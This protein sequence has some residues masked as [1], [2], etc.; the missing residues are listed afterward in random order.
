MSDGRSSRMP[1]G[2]AQGEKKSH[3]AN[4]SQHISHWTIPTFSP[5]GR[6]SPPKPLGTEWFILTGFEKI[7]K[8]SKFNFSVTVSKDM[9]F[10]RHIL[11]LLSQHAHSWVALPQG[12]LRE[13]LSSP[14][15]R[16]VLTALKPS[17][18]K[19]QKGVQSATILL[20]CC[21]TPTT[22]AN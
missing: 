19:N 4:S 15:K 3:K 17:F 14:S 21:C 6:G 13:G 2:T 20:S 22:R 12:T 18:L 16:E 8:C 11:D 1:E 5:R 9:Q 10:L 7:L